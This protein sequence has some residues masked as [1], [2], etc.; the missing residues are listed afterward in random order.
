MR[1]RIEGKK[2]KAERGK[3]ERPREG[4]GARLLE[5]GWG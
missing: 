1:E 5:A 3:E 4:T 2:G